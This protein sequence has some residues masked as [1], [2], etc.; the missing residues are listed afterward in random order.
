VI[1][2]LYLV[3]NI[4]NIPLGQW[5]SLIKR[6]KKYG[7]RGRENEILLPSLRKTQTFLGKMLKS[8]H[9]KK[10]QKNDNI[11]TKPN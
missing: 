2:D 5:I 6:Q 8:N 7:A 9:Q 10:Q 3:P 4:G 1:L 11:K